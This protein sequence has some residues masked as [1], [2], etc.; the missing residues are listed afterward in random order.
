M[1]QQPRDGHEYGATIAVPIVITVM[2]SVTVIILVVVG[3]ILVIVPV[4]MV[5]LDNPRMQ[6]CSQNRPLTM[7][8]SQNYL[9]FSLLVFFMRFRGLSGF[10]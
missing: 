7:N 1:V 6:I 8:S 4:P 9:S 5:A 2:V 10:K 3:L